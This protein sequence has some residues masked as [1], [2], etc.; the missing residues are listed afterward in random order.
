MIPS[1]TALWCWKST[2]LSVTVL[3]FLVKVCLTSC[4]ASR[5]NFFFNVL[6]HLSPCSTLTP[7]SVSK[8]THESCWMNP[9][10][11]V[12]GRKIGK[13]II[14]LS[15]PRAPWYCSRKLG[16]RSSTK[17]PM[18]FTCSSW[19][20]DVTTWFWRLHP[21]QTSISDTGLSK[22]RT[23][24]YLQATLYLCIEQR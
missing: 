13:N 15:V 16:R 4:Q 24:A 17:L 19:L 7:M 14:M 9:C 22:S 3:F 23:V 1:C 5:L 21:P 6:P 8:S 12:R 2:I 11:R 20:N 18:K 10:L